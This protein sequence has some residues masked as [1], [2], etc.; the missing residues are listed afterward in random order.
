[1]KNYKLTIRIT[2]NREPSLSF[3]EPDYATL[4]FGLN[5]N[6]GSRKYDSIVPMSYGQMKHHVLMSCQKQVADISD[7]LV[8]EGVSSLQVQLVGHNPILPNTRES[9]EDRFYQKIS[10]K[11]NE[12][13]RTILY[14]KY[15]HYDPWG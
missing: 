14:D 4:R 12:M 2:K 3:E 9:L 5:D 8:E 11:V 6:E 7:T 13:G 15:E 10:S 1:M